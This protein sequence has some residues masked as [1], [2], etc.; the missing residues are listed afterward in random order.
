MR[1]YKC[2]QCGKEFEAYPSQKRKY[3][4]NKCV[5]KANKG[6]LAGD[7]NPSKRPGVKAKMSKAQTARYAN[8][9]RV[10]CVDCGKEVSG[11]SKA[12]KRCRICHNKHISGD[13]HWSKKPEYTG[14]N[15]PCYKGGRKREC[16][17]YSTLFNAKIKDKIKERD[18]YTC[19]ICGATDV[20]LHCH[21]IDYNKFNNA[22]ENLVSLCNSCHAKTN[23]Y[24]NR[25]AW[26]KFFGHEHKVYSLVIGRFQVPKPH[27]GHEAL[28]RKL[29]NE[30]KNV[31]VM[32][33]EADLGDKNP[34]GFQKRRNAFEHLF[35]DEILSG[36]MIVMPI[37]DIEAVVYGRGVGYE[38]RQLD[39]S[40]EIE[41]I[42]GTKTRK[43]AAEEIKD[44][45]DEAFAEMPDDIM[46]LF[47]EHGL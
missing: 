6:R 10:Y 38:I 16:M 18:N 20:V 4:S 14:S 3:C 2:L 11:H 40:K 25:E 23:V 39:F 30:G 37:P 35:E 28:I 32:L 12:I 34:I 26:K 22:L 21:H 17:I 15:H 7:K 19:R 36:K 31:C 44:E 24:R 43:S 42:S 8:R 5:G 1:K 33:R 29:L 27:I 9:D 13:N 45:L 47:K 46:R 41:E